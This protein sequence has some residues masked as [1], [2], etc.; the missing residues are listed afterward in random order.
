MGKC[1]PAFVLGQF[2][3][4]PSVPR[5]ALP[6]VI[7]AG[8]LF[9]WVFH[10]VAALNET[11]QR[12]TE[13]N[14]FKQGRRLPFHFGRAQCVRAP[15]VLIRA[16]RR[17]SAVPPRQV[18]TE[19]PPASPVEM[20]P[21]APELPEPPSPEIPGV[22]PDEAPDTTPPEIPQEEGASSMAR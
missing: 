18:P 20:P 6:R 3:H 5:S 14:V 7:V 19:E 11:R 22:P 16:T 8:R 21:D 1:G 4:P 2:M 13:M 9:A 10:T 15:L 12:I 17:T